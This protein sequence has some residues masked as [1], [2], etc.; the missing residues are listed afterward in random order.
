M[1]SGGLA[2]ADLSPAEVAAYELVIRRPS[3]TLPELA[4]QWSQPE[5]LDAAMTTLEAKGFV[6]RDDEA[7]GRYRAVDPELALETPLRD[8]E[9]QLLRA[10]EHVRT[11]AATH[12]GRFTPGGSAAPIEVVTGRRA[13]E[14]RLAQLR[15]SARDEICHLDKP[16]QRS[17]PQS[18]L[19][20][21][22]AGVT[23]RTIYER[24]SVEHAG[25]LDAVEQFISAGQQVRVLPALPM[26]LYLIDA[27]HAFLP[28]QSEPASVESAIVVHPSALLDALAKLF[29]GLWLRALPLE[30]PATRDAPSGPSSRRA[31]I[32]EQR[33]V[34]L[35]LTGLTDDAI[36]RQLA[37]GYRTVQRRIAALMVKLGVHTRFQAGVQAA[38]QQH[39]DEAPR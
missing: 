16:S 11:L 22:H 7:S 3:S 20:V 14:Q 38:L 30:L 18:D 37:V 29:E 34:A 21:R 27:R 33:L 32:D 35:L 25:N 10:R 12:R 26:Q 4:K 13:V 31:P 39:G 6:T 8:Y 28:L 9:A 15:R 5:R 1:T 19:D 24:A 23:C 2:A 36:A 17:D